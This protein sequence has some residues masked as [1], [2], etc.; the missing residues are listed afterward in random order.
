MSNTLRSKVIRLAYQ[1]PDLR[2]H[3][4]PLLGARTAGVSPE[5]GEL[6][7]EFTSTG[8][9]DSDVLQRGAKVV[10]ILDAYLGKKG[11]ADVM[12]TFIDLEGGG[13]AL[14]KALLAGR[15]NPKGVVEKYFGA[16]LSEADKAER[17]NKAEGPTQGA[18]FKR[19]AEDIKSFSRAVLFHQDFVLDNL[20]RFVALR[21]GE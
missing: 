15:G 20:E 8:D 5:L 18:D 4:L 17:L 19:Y 13:A 11:G 3:L 12:P 9:R 7:D 14:R 6:L 16:I 2:P 21:D 1:Q 10:K